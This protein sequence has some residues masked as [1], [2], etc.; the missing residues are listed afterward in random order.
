MSSKEQSLS[1]RNHSC[2]RGTSLGSCA[3]GD[4]HT[5]QHPEGRYRDQ[6]K[7]TLP[8]AFGLTC[9]LV[10]GCGRT[11]GVAP[12][13]PVSLEAIVYQDDAGGL[14]DSTYRV[15]TEPAE[16]PALWRQVTSENPTKPGLPEINFDR[17]MLLIVAAGAMKAGDRIHVD[18]VGVKGDFLYAYVTVT[19][20]CAE[21]D[22]EVYPLEIVRITRTNKPVYFQTNRTRTTNCP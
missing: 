13:I 18:S 8:L 4:R 5:E 7:V 17:E 12:L 15:V 10:A 6:G 3:Q 22:L 1:A 2:N 20:A 21:L 16:W 11:A 19:Q 9:L 14:R